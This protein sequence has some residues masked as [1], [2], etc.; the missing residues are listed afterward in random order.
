MT[1][2]LTLNYREIQALFKKLKLENKIPAT[3]K[4]NQSGNQLV[5][6]I[7]AVYDCTITYERKTIQAAYKKKKKKKGGGR[8]GPRG[9]SSVLYTDKFLGKANDVYRAKESTITYSL[10]NNN[11][12]EKIGY[13]AV[14]LLP[15]YYDCISAA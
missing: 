9:Q 4:G 6:E 11:L 10:N 7:Q 5:E 2:L 15:S 1:Q 13:V 8:R 3:S 14:G 12:D